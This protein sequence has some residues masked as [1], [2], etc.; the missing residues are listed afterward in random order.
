MIGA[1]AKVEAHHFAETLQHESRANEQREGQRQLGDDE[2][3]PHA[4][5][6]HRARAA[7]AAIA[8]RTAST[9]SRLAL[10]VS[11]RLATLMQAMSSTRPDATS[12]ITNGRVR[13]PT[14]STRIEKTFAVQPS[15]AFAYSEASSVATR[16]MSRWASATVTPG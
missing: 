14:I 7:S 11:R 15:S 3:S 6:L 8:Q 10:R 2:R 5:R 4:P 9:R 12:R 16:R 13:S 1:N